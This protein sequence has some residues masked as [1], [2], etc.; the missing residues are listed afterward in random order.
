MGRLAAFAISAFIAGI[1]G[2]L[3]GY[4]QTLANA[5]SYTVFLGI[6]LFAVV[7]IAGV[8]SISGG[9]LAGVM[10]SG[11]LLYFAMEKYLHFGDWYALLAG[12][13]LVVT[14]MAN[15]DGLAHYIHEIRI[16]GFGTKLGDDKPVL[17]AAHIDAGTIAPAADAP[18]GGCCSRPPPSVFATAR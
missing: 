12:V 11:G 1:G 16:P 10:A 14:V 9:I 18:T 8:T 4:Q 2:A 6:G 5:S 17:D 7:Y 3:I 15:P 13:L